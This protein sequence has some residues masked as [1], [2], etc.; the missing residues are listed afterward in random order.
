LEYERNF[1]KP[2][3]SEEIPHHDNSELGKIGHNVVLIDD[4]SYPNAG[5]RITT[6]LVK[7]ITEKPN[8][9]VELHTHDVDQVFVFMGE[10]DNEDSLEIEFTFDTETYRIKSP[11][12]V[13]VPKGIPHTQKIIGGSGRYFT[14]LKEGTYV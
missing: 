5:I 13:F 10:P 14:L 12:T 7:E 1:I 3:I 4:R 11:I 8:D 9:Y 2:R 6:R